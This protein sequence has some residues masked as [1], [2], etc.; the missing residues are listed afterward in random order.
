MLKNN[1]SLSTKTLRNEQY[2]LREN[3]ISETDPFDSM[4][5]M[6][7]NKTSGKDRLTKEFHE[8]LWDKENSSHG[9]CKSSFPY[10]NLKY[11]TKASYHQA[12]CKKRP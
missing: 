8:T 4:K 5:S 9:K 3:K 6:S 12:H 10:G 2:D 11:F 7:N 1:N